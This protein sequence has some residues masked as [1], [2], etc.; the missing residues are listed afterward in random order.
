MLKIVIV[1]VKK[2]LSTAVANI[3]TAFKNNT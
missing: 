3:H 2:F 1:F